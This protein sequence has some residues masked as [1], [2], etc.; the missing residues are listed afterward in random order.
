MPHTPT[1]SRSH[2]LP[3]IALAGVAFGLAFLFRDHLT[4]DALA[5]N[6]DAFVAFRD[7]NFA[8]T[9]L[10]FM[11]IYAGIVA[12]SLPGATVATLTGGF[13]FSTFPGVVFNVAGATVGATLL[14][15]AARWGLGDWLSSK[16]DT[17]SERIRKVKAGID[18]NQWSMLFFIRLV[19][20]VPFFVANLLPALLGVPFSRFVI[21]T[22]IGI[23]PGALVYTSVGAGLGVVF[24]RGEV[25]DLGV[26][27]EPHILLPLIGLAALS[28]V[29]VLLKVVREGRAK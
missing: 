18:D 25:P 23:I 1:K 4:F 14:F 10:I 21:S 20:V 15:V 9:A 26:I 16:M 6:R 2:A 27:F 28:L 24:A 11:A 22:A 8:L 17:G 13:L 12:F 19:P 5:A 3:L 29:P 7:Q